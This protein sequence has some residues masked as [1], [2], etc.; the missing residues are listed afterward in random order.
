MGSN[1]LNMNIVNNMLSRC[2][3]VILNVFVRRVLHGG[4]KELFGV[5]TVWMRILEIVLLRIKRF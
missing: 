2:E 5:S 3:V 4:A 1:C